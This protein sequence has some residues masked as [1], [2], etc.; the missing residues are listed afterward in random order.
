MRL[1]SAFFFFWL[2]CDTPAIANTSDALQR[3][4]DVPEFILLNKHQ[5]S[6]VARLT[7]RK[8]KKV[9][10][11]ERI[12]SE[13]ESAETHLKERRGLKTPPFINKRQEAC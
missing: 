6:D 5:V 13:A 12:E 8:K 1:K 3:G 11:Q 10:R 4:S 9:N 7:R 2:W